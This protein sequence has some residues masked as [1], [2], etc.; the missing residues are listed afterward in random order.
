[1]H[2]K[3]RLQDH[4]ALSQQRLLA[5]ALCGALLRSVG[6]YLLGGVVVLIDPAQHCR[7]R[8]A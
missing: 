8:Q 4:L 1:M 3:Q 5:L 6:A 2:V 7:L